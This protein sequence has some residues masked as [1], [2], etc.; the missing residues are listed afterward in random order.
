LV[1]RTDDSIVT[2]RVRKM[3]DQLI[4]IRVRP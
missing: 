3:K 4:Y 1:K 2:K